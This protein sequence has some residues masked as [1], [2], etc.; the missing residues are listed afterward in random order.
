MHHLRW[1][2]ACASMQPAAV[3]VSIQ[4]TLQYLCWPA[5]SLKSR[6]SRPASATFDFVCASARRR[7]LALTPP[8]GSNTRPSLLSWRQAGFFVLPLL[9]N[10]RLCYRG[11]NSYGAL[12]P[13]LSP[14]C[15]WTIPLY[16]TLLLLLRQ[17]LTSH[18][19]LSVCSND[20]LQ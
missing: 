13:F 16:L 18:R 1:W 19:R 15:G 10:L 17:Q 8:A 9:P 11:F 3:L 6:A 4:R 5:C 20:K 12:A 7:H 14:G 2:A